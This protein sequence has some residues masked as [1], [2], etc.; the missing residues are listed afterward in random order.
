VRGHA[1]RGIHNLKEENRLPSD[2]GGSLL[3]GAMKTI[4]TNENH[5]FPPRKKREMVI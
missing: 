4:L 2:R 3:K 1:Q 5:N